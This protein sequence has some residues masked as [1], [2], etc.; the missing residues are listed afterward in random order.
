MVSIRVEGTVFSGEGV[1][2]S[3]VV[4]PWVKDQ[5]RKKFGFDPYPGTLNL[6][7]L[8]EEAV[9]LRDKLR[10]MKGIEIKPKRGFYKANC[11]HVKVSGKVNGY[12]LIPEKPDYP[13]NVLEIVTAKCLR[14]TLSLDD[15]DKVELTFTLEFKEF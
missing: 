10:K 13:L 4:L 14:D 15:G 6:R 5:V 11:F 3:F 8:D 7:L 1:G 12:V 2:A 9:S